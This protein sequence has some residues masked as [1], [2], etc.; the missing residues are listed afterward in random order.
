MKWI[1]KK[2][3]KIFIF[4]NIIFLL[5]IFNFISP[6][7][8]FENQLSNLIFMV[9]ILLI[10]FLL[11]IC[12]FFLENLF[13]KIIS[14]IIEGLISIIAFA[15]IFIILINIGSTIEAGYN[16]G[17][18]KIKSYQA[19]KYEV[20]TYRS[21]GGAT[22]SYGIA[23]RQEKKILLGIILVRVIYREYPRYDI[24]YE[25]NNNVLIIESKEYIL[26]EFVY[27]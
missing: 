24:E 14:I 26:K 19:E 6:L 8:R 9:I 11:T 20:N 16:P 22:T 2:K 15:F 23:I 27:Q 7:I 18:E 25:I 4:L 12:G 21:N 10:P 3:A 17:F 13:V 1:I 5:S